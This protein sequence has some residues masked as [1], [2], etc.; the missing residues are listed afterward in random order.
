MFT[1]ISFCEV[2][3]LIWGNYFLLFW[4]ILIFLSSNIDGLKFRSSSIEVLRKWLLL[5]GLFK[6][7]TDPSLLIKRAGEFGIFILPDAPKGPVT[8]QEN[9]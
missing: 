6:I 1:V 5:Y 3:V 8:H 7:P 2:K 4:D 9:N